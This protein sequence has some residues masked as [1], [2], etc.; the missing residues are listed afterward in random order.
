MDRVVSEKHRNI[1]V[2]PGLLCTYGQQHRAKIVWV[3]QS[4]GDEI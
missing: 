4:E 3:I 2:G 1:Q